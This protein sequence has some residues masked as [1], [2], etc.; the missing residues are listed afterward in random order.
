[1]KLLIVSVLLHIAA[2]LTS[3]ADERESKY[4]KNRIIS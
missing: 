3:T 1:M 4:R 2:I